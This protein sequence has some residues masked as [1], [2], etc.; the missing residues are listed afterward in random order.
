MNNID[1]RYRYQ[2]PN[3]LV[4]DMSILGKEKINMYIDDRLIQTIM[5]KRSKAYEV[6]SNINKQI[7]QKEKE[8]DIWQ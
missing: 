3:K 8:V 4:L 6:L 2:I 7:I 1:L 5:V